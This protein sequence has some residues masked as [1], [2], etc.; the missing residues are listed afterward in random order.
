MIGYLRGSVLALE[1]KGLILD[2]G[3]VGYRVFAAQD[4]LAALKKERAKEAA[5]FTYLSVREDALELFGFLTKEELRFFEQLIS[6]SGIGPKSALGIL[7]STS[8]ERLSS[9]IAS[10]DTGY[11]TKISGIGR[12]T[13]EKI[14]LELRE[15]MGNI[16]ESTGLR[17]ETDALE[18]LR[19]LGYGEREIRDAL[20]KI[21][22]S[23][24]TKERIKEALKILSS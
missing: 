3:G 1:E 4:T 6:I 21:A 17:E 12:K 23:A 16:E 11:L 10:G 15:K 5:L 8:V 20:K 13:A 22:A 19:S 18:A 9:A 7:S 24:T 14:V 2:V